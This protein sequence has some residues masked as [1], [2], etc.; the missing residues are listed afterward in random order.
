[1]RS[2]SVRLKPLMSHVDAKPSLLC[3]TRAAT[4]CRLR[5]LLAESFLSVTQPSFHLIPRGD[6]MATQDQFMTA[7]EEVAGLTANFSRVDEDNL[8]EALLMAPGTLA[9]LRMIAGWDTVHQA[10]EDGVPY[11]AL[12]YQR[13]VGGAW[14]QVQAAYSEVKG[15]NVLELPLERLL[16][17]EGVP[18][19]RSPAGATG[20]AATARRYGVSPGPDFVIP[21]V[22]PAVIIESKVAEDGGTVRDKASRIGT[23]A[24]AGRRAGLVVCAL[25]DGKGWRERPG[26]LADVIIATEGRTYTLSTVGHL[27]E[28]PD[29]AGLRGTKPSAG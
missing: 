24:E 13:Y 1:M 25:V 28:V 10:A 3:S 17:E 19:Y 8:T 29:I 11:S 16:I 21:D 5:S 6:A 23:L 14:L 12:L 4:I 27:L 7:Y 22:Q 15:D 2:S 9:P 18:Y 26:A 20:A